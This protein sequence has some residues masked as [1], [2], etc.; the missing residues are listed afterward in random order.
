MG[1]VFEA[2]GVKECGLGRITVVLYSYRPNPPLTPPLA[3]VW[4][5]LGHTTLTHTCPIAQG[6]AG[7]EGVG[8]GI[9]VRKPCVR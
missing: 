3:W 2:R 8:R 5:L 9:W 7:G 6:H 4:G 1:A